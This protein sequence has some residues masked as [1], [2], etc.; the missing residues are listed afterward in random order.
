MAAQLQQVDSSI[1]AQELAGLLE[2][3]GAVIVTNALDRDQLA[4][5]NAELDD[6]IAATDPGLR[7]P[8]EDRMVE[9]Y[10]NRTIRLDGLPARSRT[11]L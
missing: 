2:R 1:D 9:F 6:A 8:T 11:C 4:G 3:D 7:N 5:I 10:G